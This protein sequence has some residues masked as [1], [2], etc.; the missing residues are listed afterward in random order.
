MHKLTVKHLQELK[1]V[2][3]ISFVQEARLEEAIAAEAGMD[4]IGT[5][6]REET[7]LFTSPV[8]ES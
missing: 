2:R 4:M 8:P 7:R 5:G 6:I 3:Q 1:G